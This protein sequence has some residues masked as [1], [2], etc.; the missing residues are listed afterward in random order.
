MRG[1]DSERKVLMHDDKK[2][3][4]ANTAKKFAYDQTLGALLNTIAFIVGMGLLKGKTTSTIVAD[5]QKDFWPITT[6]GLKLWPL[7]SLF[8]F[9]VV[10]VEKRVIVGGIVGIGWGVYLS[11][12]AG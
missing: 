7:V 1:K 9:A 10:P 3:S 8:N 5:V 6:N 2:F 12:M 11:L 4:V